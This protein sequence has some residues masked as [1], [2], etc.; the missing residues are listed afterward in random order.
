MAILVTAL[1]GGF[2]AAA[3]FALD[4]ALS[5]RLTETWLR[6]MVINVSGSALLGLLTGLAA[7]QLV[8]PGFPMVLGAG[9]LGGY[10]T[11]SA[12]SLATV[13]TI[14]NRRW[15]IALTSSVGMLLGSTAAAALGLLVGLS[16]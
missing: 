1:A 10:T 9:F 2:G 4:T 11:F 5:R 13:R 3:R 16:L 8:A 15:V 7:Q 6:L 14:E 12:A